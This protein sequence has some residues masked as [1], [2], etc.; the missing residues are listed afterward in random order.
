VITIVAATGLC[1]AVALARYGRAGLVRLADL[2]LQHAWLL[3]V[4]CALQAALVAELVAPFWCTLV[5][6]LLI[7][8]FALL[9]RRVPGLLLAVGGALLNLLVMLAHGGRMP[10]HPGT[11]ELLGGAAPASGEILAGTKGV[12][13]AGESLW[14]LLGDWLPLPG[15]VT[16][17]ALW[18]IGD[19][20]LLAGI[21]T[22]LLQTM[23]GEH[24]AAVT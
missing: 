2:R 23:R 21:L 16:G 8:A 3:V 4:A 15:A 6:S 20:I 14:L 9:N 24:H 18:S 19:L 7:G 13:G 22:L 10:A 11:L 5:S 1:F 12:V 17:V